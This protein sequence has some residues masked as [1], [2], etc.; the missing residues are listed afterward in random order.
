MNNSIKIFITGG[1]GFIGYYFQQY[2][3]GETTIFDLEEPGF[4]HSA[5]YI[6]G[7]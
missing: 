3:N 7:R 2:I 1:S 4:S 5:N 6:K